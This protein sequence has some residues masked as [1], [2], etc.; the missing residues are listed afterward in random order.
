MRN[1]VKE[2][3][4]NAVSIT[5]IQHSAFDSS[6]VWVASDGAAYFVRL[7]DGRTPPVYRLDNPTPSS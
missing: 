6:E 1:L 5:S 7:D 4:D 2:T 3:N